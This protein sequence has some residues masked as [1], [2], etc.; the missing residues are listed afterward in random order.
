MQKVI[1]VIFGDIANTGQA[2]KAQY[3]SKRTPYEVYKQ[4]DKDEKILFVDNFDK[5]PLNDDYRKKV[6]AKFEIHF[7]TIFIT[8][9]D[10][11]GINSLN[12]SYTLNFKVIHFIFL[13]I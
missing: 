2:Y 13:Q 7:G 5:C 12:Y 3:D 6:I 8:I 4:L 1:V 10:D 9:K 11:V